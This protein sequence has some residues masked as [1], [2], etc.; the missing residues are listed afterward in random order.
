MNDLLNDILSN[1]LIAII[2]GV[3]SDS[4]LQVAEA[5][6]KGG[7]NF[8]EVTYRPGDDIAS[9]DT[10]KSIAMIKERYAGKIHVGAGTVL[11][12]EDVDRAYEAGAEYIISPN[13]NVDVIRRTKELQLISMPGALTPTEIEQAWEA[14]ADVVKVFPAHVFGPKYFK[15]VKGPLCSVKLAAVGGI[16]A[17]NINEFLKAGA[18]CFGIANS[19]VN[20][21]RVNRQ[22]WDEITAEAEA[23]VRAVMEAQEVK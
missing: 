9:A 7:I 19:L 4:V 17:G 20:A 10:L 1:K 21:D 6:V 11:T 14:G 8:M 18:D 2:R 15:D 23:C 5:L 3:P 13:V 22:A 16:G 12:V